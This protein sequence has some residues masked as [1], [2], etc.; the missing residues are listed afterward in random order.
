[1]EIATR[2]I[3]TFVMLK[4]YCQIRDHN[5]ALGIEEIDVILH[6]KAQYRKI[7]SLSADLKELDDVARS[8]QKND[9]TVS[10]CRALLD[11]LLEEYLNLDSRLA[12]DARIVK[13]PIFEIEMQKVQENRVGM[14]TLEE[15]AELEEFRRIRTRDARSGNYPDDC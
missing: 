8:L 2:W 7:Q 9:A 5:C 1:M 3:S 4:R 13:Y 10:S 15:K 11:T 14:L 12:L 6:N